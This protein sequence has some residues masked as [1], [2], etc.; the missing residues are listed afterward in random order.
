[1][2]R[3]LNQDTARRFAGR[4]GPDVLFNY[5]GQ[6]ADQADPAGNSDWTLAAQTR[7]VADAADPSQPLRHALTIDAGV[8]AG[9]LTATW[10]W[11]PSCCDDEEISRLAMRWVE[12][13]TAFAADETIGGFTPADLLV[14][15]NQKDIDLLE[16]AWG[17]LS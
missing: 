8:F 17:K 9:E 13:L 2:L 16:E 1:M 12:I 11:A 7:L 3:Y 4:P 5:L 10:T 6:L 14:D 15:L